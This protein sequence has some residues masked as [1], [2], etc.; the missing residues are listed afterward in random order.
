MPFPLNPANGQV[1]LV[2]NINYVWDNSNGVWNRQTIGSLNPIS[3]NLTLTGN[4]I[5]TGG[6][7]TG[8]GTFYSNG[9]VISG[10]GTG[11]T[12]VYTKSLTFDG[13]VVTGTGT[14]RW[15]PDSAITIANIY[16][17]A[18]TPPVSGNMSLRINK[19]GSSVF[20]FANL[21]SGIYRSNNYTI[22]TTVTTTDYITV[23]VV[24]NGGA[25]DATLTFTYTRN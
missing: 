8:T 5:A 19:N 10:G 21:T 18:S 15:Y 4:L 20:T 22:N 2:N 24:N 7:Y 1:A 9:T 23:D 6:V 11:T 16:I 13:L 12:V 25:Q 14:A 3:G 17:T